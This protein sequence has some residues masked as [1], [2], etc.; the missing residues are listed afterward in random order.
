LPGVFARRPDDF[1]DLAS[2][3]EIFFTFFPLQAAINRKIVEVVWHENVP[4][5]AQK[6]PLFRNG[7][8]NPAT[9]KVEVWWLWDGV[10]DWKVGKLTP[11]QLD[12]PILSIPSYPVLIDRI[13][14]GWTPQ[15]A[16]EFIDRAREKMKRNGTVSSPPA[17]VEE[18]RHYLIFNDR[19][20]AEQAVQQI[21]DLGLQ[22]GMTDL[23][24]RWGVNVLQPELALDKI[25]R[26][27]ERLKMV[28][29]ALGG[30]YDGN[31]LKLGNT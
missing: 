16:E 24:E 20:S 26:I 9:G 25:E 17:T 30:I 12:L 3:K 28:A 4:D 21:C 29:S 11:E 14:T 5:H 15:S 19:D 22:A 18:M 2:V 13:E 31:Q 6:F 1:K 7:L 27:A 8:P 10:K 23:G